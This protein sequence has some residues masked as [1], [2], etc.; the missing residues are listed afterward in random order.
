MK[1]M[2]NDE[3]NEMGKLIARQMLSSD[4]FYRK[5]FE[6][7]TKMFFEDKLFGELG[8]CEIYK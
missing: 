7:I 6:Q 3:I 1:Y 2:T 4:K 5:D 8:D